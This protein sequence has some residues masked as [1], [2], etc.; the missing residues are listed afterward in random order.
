M[1]NTD[2][3]PVNNVKNFQ[4]GTLE[5]AQCER[6]FIA[7]F[8]LDDILAAYNAMDGVDPIGRDEL[9]AI[10]GSLVGGWPEA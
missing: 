5:S 3:Y 8:S 2:E 10:M 7:V 9:A 1:S 4:I 6:S